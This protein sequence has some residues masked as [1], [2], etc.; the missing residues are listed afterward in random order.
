MNRQT[1]VEAYNE[2]REK[3]LIKKLQFFTYDLLF[4]YGPCTSGELMERVQREHPEWAVRS[5]DSCAKRLP[6][7]RA[8]GLVREL[9]ERPCLTSGRRAIVWDVTNQLPAAP[10]KKLTKDQTIAALRARVAELE[11]LVNR[12]QLSLL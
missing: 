8:R 6:E 7:L 12:G 2:I 4:K 11:R 10:E 3:G 5:L 1:S 9:G